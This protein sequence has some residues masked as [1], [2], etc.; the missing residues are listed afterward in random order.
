MS[1]TR[2][3]SYV[4]PFCTLSPE[5]VFFENSLVRGI[6]DA[7][8]VSA[9]H[10]LLIPKRHVAGWFETTSEEKLA[11]IEAIDAA[12]REIERLHRPTATTSA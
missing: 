8:P 2:L 10:A 7:Y 11:L 5:R 12:K 6:W 4:C 3:P 1:E 9:G